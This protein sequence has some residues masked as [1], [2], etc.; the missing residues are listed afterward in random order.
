MLT[1]DEL[2]ELE[3]LCK[4]RPGQ[5]FAELA[6][7]V[8]TAYRAERARAASEWERAWHAEQ[9]AAALRLENERLG[10]RLSRAETMLKAMTARAP[11]RKEG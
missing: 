3:K 4:A 2:A 5:H 6:A 11:E 10:V 1:D 9:A 8:A 7:R